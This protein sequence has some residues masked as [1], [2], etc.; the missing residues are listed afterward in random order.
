MVYQNRACWRPKD[1]VN[2]LSGI[3]LF[4]YDFFVIMFFM[5]RSFKRQQCWRFFAHLMNWANLIFI[6][7]VLVSIVF[8][9][10]TSSTIIDKD[11][12]FTM[13]QFMVMTTYT[14][15]SIFLYLAVC[16]HFFDQKLAFVH[17]EV[18]MNKLSHSV[19]NLEAFIKRTQTGV[20]V[21]AVILYSLFDEAVL[22]P[23]MGYEGADYDSFFQVILLQ[24]FLPC[25]LIWVFLFAYCLHYTIFMKGPAETFVNFIP[26][27]NIILLSVLAFPLSLCVVGLFALLEVKIMPKDINSFFYSCM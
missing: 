12:K 6:V 23:D 24:S 14:T 5:I 17:K 3:V 15:R 9:I 8:I 11:F 10:V 7:N 16:T 2:L 25:C 13:A 26:P 19:G 21:V 20:F 4:M 22:F 18:S 27:G 1:V